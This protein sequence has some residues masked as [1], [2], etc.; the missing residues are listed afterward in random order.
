MQSSS[1][2]PASRCSRNTRQADKSLFAHV[3]P[4]DWSLVEGTDVAL[5]AFSQTENDERTSNRK[6]ETA[7][8]NHVVFLCFSR[9]Y[10]QH[11]LSLQNSHCTLLELL[12]AWATRAPKSMNYLPENEALRK[13]KQQEASRGTMPHPGQRDLLFYNRKLKCLVAAE[14][15]QGLFRPEYKGQM[16]LYLRWLA[17]R[18]RTF[19]RARPAAS[20]REVTSQG[21]RRS[22]ADQVPV[23]ALLDPDDRTVPWLGAGDRRRS[24]RCF[25]ASM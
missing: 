12:R 18:D 1:G 6:G 23:M 20:L 15:K 2:A 22:G 5:A 14:L 3:F 17:K 8:N 9:V 16:E 25:R 21:R 11:T 24:Q 10:S 19:R 4:T 7:Q 13:V